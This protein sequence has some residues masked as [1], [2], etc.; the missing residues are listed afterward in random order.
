MNCDQSHRLL[1]D[2]FL[3]PNT[4][5][6]GDEMRAHLMT[7]KACVAFR[8]EL[9]DMGKTFLRDDKENP[10][11]FLVTEI[12]E[13]WAKKSRLGTFNFRRFAF[14]LL[15][16]L[17]LFAFVYVAKNLMTDPYK[18]KIDN[19]NPKENG[20]QKKHEADSLVADQQTVQNLNQKKQ[21]DDSVLSFINPAY[22]NG[23]VQNSLGGNSDEVS[24]GSKPDQNRDE[25][26]Y[27]K[28]S[29]KLKKN[30]KGEVKTKVVKEMVLVQGENKDGENTVASVNELKS[31]DSQ[32]KIE[33][34]K[35]ETKTV[36]EDENHIKEKVK[37]N[38]LHLTGMKNTNLPAGQLQNKMDQSVSLVSEADQELDE[39]KTDDLEDKGDVQ[40]SNFEEFQ[41]QNG[42]TTKIEALG[43]IIS[44]SEE[45][46]IASNV[47]RDN[48]PDCTLTKGIPGFVSNFHGV[49]TSQRLNLAALVKAVAGSASYQRIPGSVISGFSGKELRPSRPVLVLPPS[50]YQQL[51]KSLLGNPVLSMLIMGPDMQ[52]SYPHKT[53][54]EGVTQRDAVQGK[55]SAVSLDDWDKI[56]EALNE[57]DD[58]ELQ[59]GVT[60]N[61]AANLLLTQQSQGQ[62]ED[63]VVPDEDNVFPQEDESLLNYCPNTI[64]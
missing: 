49:R 32:I 40:Q 30:L 31:K 41:K 1:E 19:V 52:N 60:R 61:N 54:T 10:S 18:S 58:D 2:D 36:M 24:N 13:K 20:V 3:T 29:Q 7:C 51:M 35:T 15:S 6:F 47:K 55:T 50:F 64:R 27:E 62:V 37:T 17:A 56:D 59:S 26:N 48:P 22:Q 11:S 43:K 46:Q 5:K 14:L 8:E 42:D 38:I 39:L 53:K 4:L 16:G 34:I 9:A 63:S 25:N 12:R 33:K 23:A 44:G 21:S 57:V 45:D 28:I